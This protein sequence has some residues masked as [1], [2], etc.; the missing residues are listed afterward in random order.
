LPRSRY[1]QR[2]FRLSLPELNLTLRWPLFPL[3]K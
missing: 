3:L 2:R 1:R